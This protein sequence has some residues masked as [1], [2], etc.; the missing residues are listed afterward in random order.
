MNNAAPNLKNAKDHSGQVKFGHHVVTLIDFLGQ[1]SE[2]VK[3]DLL[4]ETEYDE[5]K[6]IA[7]VR[8][9]FGKITIWR[10]QFEEKFKLWLDSRELPDSWTKALPDKGRAYREF[11]HTTLDFMHFSDTIV[12]Y[13]PVV[14]QYGYANCGTVMAHLFTCGNLMLAALC[15]NTVFRGAIEIGM[16]GQIDEAGIYG[17]ALAVAHQL[18]SKVAGYPRIVAGPRLHEYLVAQAADP[19]NSAPSRTNRGIANTC[20]RLLGQDLDGN[21]VID[22]AGNGF[23][24]LAT[25]KDSWQLLREGAHAFVKRELDRFR[26]EGDQKLAERYERMA[27][28][29]RSRGFEG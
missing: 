1:Q 19:D 25:K 14:N 13:S 21:R 20:L 4:P 27:A 12:I 6:F 3:W 22:Y 23:V 15:Q 8:A 5:K 2:L 16:A 29:F 26:R 9:T 11:A 17:P 24:D 7:A 28:Y 18:E 10:D